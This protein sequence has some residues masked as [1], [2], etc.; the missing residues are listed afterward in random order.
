MTHPKMIT[1]DG[2]SA[3]YWQQRKVAFALIREAEEAGQAMMEAPMYRYGSG[4]NEF[5]DPVVEDN[6]EPWDEFE[7]AIRQLQ[8]N[9]TAVRIL[10]AQRRDEIHGTRLD[11]VHQ[12][13]ILDTLPY[14]DEPLVWVEPYGFI[15][16]NTD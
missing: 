6:I 5:G 1:V 13:I 3:E 15:G 16:P 10:I 14:G 7:E 9:D 12:G 2:G 11:K 4:C 8:E